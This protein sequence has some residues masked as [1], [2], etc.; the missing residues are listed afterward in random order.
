VAGTNDRL[1]DTTG[2][3]NLA[4]TDPNKALDNADNHE[5]FAENQR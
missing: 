3:L 5:Y 4:K 2:A 1:D